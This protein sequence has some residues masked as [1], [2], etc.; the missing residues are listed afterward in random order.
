MPNTASHTPHILVCGSLAIDTILLFNGVFSDHILPENLSELSVAFYT[1][2]MRREYGGCA[3]N[4]G[5]ALSQLGVH[6]LICATLGKDG[7]HY[8][9]RLSDMGISTDHIATQPEHFTAQ[10]TLIT[11][12]NGRQITAF[13]P[14]AMA[15][16]HHNPIPENTQ[17]EL[18]ILS[19]DGKDAT[20]LHAQQLHRCGTPFVFDPGQA[21]PM[22]DREQLLHLITLA[23]WVIVNEYEAELLTDCTGLTATDIAGMVRAYIVTLGSRG[24]SIHQHGTPPQTLAAPAATAQ[25]DPT[26][27]G[28]A[29]RGGL[30]LGLARGWSPADGC[31]LGNRLGAH[32]VAHHGGQNYTLDDSFRQ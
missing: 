25:L 10:A 4:I 21:L 15:H 14:G 8:L 27:C 20:L 16:A 9:Q 12:S 23:D 2:E 24:C 29:F 17:A 5:Y 22:F 32:K 7:D 1:E 30:L 19:P 11:D 28:D 13:H 18:A 26:G 3:G 31:V 6:P